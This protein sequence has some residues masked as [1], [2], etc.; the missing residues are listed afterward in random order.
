MQ[1]QPILDVLQITPRDIANA[2]KPVAQSTSVDG[3]RIRRTVGVPAAIQI[4]GERRDQIGVLLAVVT[5]Q[6]TQPFHHE[7]VNLWP[8][9]SAIKDAVHAEVLE[10][11]ATV[12]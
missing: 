4:L 10:A 8:I 12:W 6:R 5:Q 3:E 1:V 2:A 7:V 9:A 11:S